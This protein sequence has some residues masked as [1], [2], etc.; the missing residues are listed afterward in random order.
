MLVSNRDKLD[1]ELEVLIDKCG[2]DRTALMPILQAVQ[3]TYGFVSDFVMQKIAD[4][5]GIHPVEVH[6]V[7][8]FY[9]FLSEKPSGRFT[10][11][12]CQTISCDMAGKARVATQLENELGIKF[13]QTTDDGMFTLEWANC[14]GL[15]DQGPA[16]LVNDAA[17]TQVTPQ[18]VLEIV[19]ECRARLSP[20]AIQD[21]EEHL[22]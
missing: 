21:K 7:V 11:R 22:V 6:G 10:I 13:G 16:I 17:Y 8:S 12:L 15:C 4:A 19:E 1:Q 2:R 20:H 3:R 9:S 5:L 14:M 18:R